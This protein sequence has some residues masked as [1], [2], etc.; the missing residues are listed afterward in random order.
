MVRLLDV[1][2]GRPPEPLLVSSL[3]RTSLAVSPDQEIVYRDQVRYDYRV[4]RERIGRLAASLKRLGVTEGATVAVMDWDSHRYLE[5]YFAVPM[6]GAVLM[7]VNLRLSTEQ[8]RYTLEHARAEVLLV[9]ADF[10]ELIA[11]LA[12]R[13]PQLRCIVVLEPPGGV[14]GGLAVGEYEELLARETEG[15]A[16]RE[17]DENAVATTLHDGNDRPAQGR[18][19]QPP[20]VGAPYA[21]GARCAGQS[22]VRPVAAPRRRLHAAD[23]DVPRARLGPALCRDAARPEAGL[24]G[25]V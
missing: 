6:M 19:L 9:H 7:T 17:F 8:I 13:L 14:A 4:L 21:C 25:P 5:A 22:A 24:S 23:A 1:P 16:F 10:L 18:V 3:L 11:G 15:F 12:D 2:G 20:A